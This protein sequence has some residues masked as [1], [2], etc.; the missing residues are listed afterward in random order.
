MTAKRTTAEKPDSKP[1]REC[2]A[3]ATNESA[4]TRGDDLG[5]ECTLWQA[6]DRL[7]NKHGRRRVQAHRDG[8]P[9]RV[10]AHPEGRPGSYRV[11]GALT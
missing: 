5:F 8:R 2:A 3:K 7:R 6:A 11:R 4:A 10:Q 1:R 9:G